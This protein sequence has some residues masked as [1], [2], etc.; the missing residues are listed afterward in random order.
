MTQR[1]PWSNKERKERNKY[2]W[3]NRSAWQRKWNAHVRYTKQQ[4]NQLNIQLPLTKEMA[5]VGEKK[6]KKRNRSKKKKKKD[7]PFFFVIFRLLGFFWLRMTWKN[8]QFKETFFFNLNFIFFSL[9]VIVSL[10]KST[11][12]G[13]R[14]EEKFW[15]VSKTELVCVFEAHLLPHPHFAQRIFLFYFSERDT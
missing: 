1:E 9:L 15:N 12:F 13:S 11:A 7:F 8:E 5:T 6:T 2:W 14:D 3:Q 10:E 4:R